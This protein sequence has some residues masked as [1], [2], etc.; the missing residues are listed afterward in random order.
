VA[1]VNVIEKE[2]YVK[3]VYYGPALSGKTSNLEYIQRK[4]AA[5]KTDLISI[6]T[7]GDRTLYFDFLPLEAKIIPG[8]TT[9]FQ[10]YTVPGQVQYNATR[11]LVLQG[12]DGIIFV[13]DSQWS[14][15]EANVESF[16][17]M[18]ENIK[19]YGIDMQE[20]PYI[21]QYNKRDLP[22]VA[23]LDH[24]EYLLNRESVKVPSFESV[25]LTGQGVFDS[26][27]AICKMVVGKI[28]KDIKSR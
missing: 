9:K 26:L 18:K 19:E 12:A 16:R 3:V 5:Q 6:A 27:N 14:R 8:F 11:K 2:I 17:D 21:L 15:Q 10:L 7:E 24:M 13:A 20:F 25:A 23:K 28:L 22:E 4:I 1:Q